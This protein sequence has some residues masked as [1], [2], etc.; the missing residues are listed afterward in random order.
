MAMDDASATKATLGIHAIK[1]NAQRIA[2]KM[3][4]VHQEQVVKGY[5]VYAR[6]VGRV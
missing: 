6:K 2:M 4:T 5:I 1:L 3:V